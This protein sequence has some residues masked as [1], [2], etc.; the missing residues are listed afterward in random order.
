MNN[1]EP[2]TPAT[3][4][5]YI[6]LQNPS[7]FCKSSNPMHPNSKWGVLADHLYGNNTIQY[8]KLLQQLS[9][10]SS[11]QKYHKTTQSHI[12][13]AISTIN[14]FHL[15]PS[16]FRHQNSCWGKISEILYASNTFQ[17]RNFLH[18]LY[19]IFIQNNTVSKQIKDNP[20]HC[21]SHSV[22]SVTHYNLQVLAT[23]LPATSLR[24]PV[25]A[26]RQKKVDA[27]NRRKTHYNMNREQ[28]LQHKTSRRLSISHSPPTV[29]LIL[30][31]DLI[32][33]LCSNFT[34]QI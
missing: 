26:A 15:L 16:N 21:S 27:S 18:S 7:S 28:I 30:H 22:D 3:T 6:V 23:S 32:T 8:R 14:N 20:E 10:I 9:T 1:S 24:Q 17:D 29:Q 11:E 13:A 19:D 33:E 31:T 12:Q 34:Q 5:W 25:R 2:V 4:S